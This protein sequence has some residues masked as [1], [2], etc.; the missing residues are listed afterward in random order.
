MSIQVISNDILELRFN[1]SKLSDK[2]LIDEIK[3]RFNYVVIENKKNYEFN[4]DVWGLIKSFMGIYD[5]HTQWNKLGKMS[6]IC[7]T[8]YFSYTFGT[9][10]NYKNSKLARKEIL[11][12]L[13]KNLTLKQAI[14]LQIVFKPLMQ[15]KD[16]FNADLC[17]NF[18]CPLYVD[19]NTAKYYHCR[20]FKILSI[21]QTKNKL[22]I[23]W[24]EEID[25]PIRISHNY[26]EPIRIH[27][28]D[29]SIKVVEREYTEVS[30]EMIPKLNK[31]FSKYFREYFRDFD[32]F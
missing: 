32:W 25:E 4:N 13:L 2:I 8:N 26:V 5:L 10:I 17:S 23:F 30:I 1:I 16:V 29:K 21:S 14:H 11:S 27:H 19:R 28:Y 3:R 31:Y 6:I 9:K 12:S 24:S 18:N 22:R 7:L 20:T 15:Y